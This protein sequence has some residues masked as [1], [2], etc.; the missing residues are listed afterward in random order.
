MKIAFYSGEMG[1]KHASHI[2][3]LLKGHAP[4][5]QYHHDD[6][7]KADL[8]HC[9]MPHSSI[10][11]IAKA[12]RS[13]IT[14][15]D[16]TFITHPEIYSLK[17]RLFILPLYRYHCRHAARLIALNELSRRRLVESL[18]LDESSVVVCSSTASLPRDAAPTSEEMLSLRERLS[19][20]DSY[21]LVCGQMD[22]MHGHTTILH[23]VLASPHSLSVVIYGRRTTHSDVL[24][25]AVRDAGAA[26]RIQFIYEVASEDI[27]SL[28]RMALLMIYLP[29]FDSSITP[30]IEALHQGVAMILSTTPLNREVAAQAAIY[31]EPYDEQALSAA[32]E[33]VIYNES[34]R[35]QL[36]AQT[37]SES[38]RYS[39]EGVVERL[40][41]IY[42]EVNT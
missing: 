24:L 30:I 23:S 20:P 37:V 34:F 18:G 2:I 32:I 35:G 25:E 10:L 5:H 11:F 8:W 12:S 39:K 33:Q 4:H 28:Y 31:V 21:I 36:L 3:E 40:V 1:K 27:A 42:E 9:M 41:Q 16:L 6:S 7:S 38:R 15:S 19:L 14:L 13:V 26:D 22:T 17:E 29:T